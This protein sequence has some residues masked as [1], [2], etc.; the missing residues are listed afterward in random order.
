[1]AIKQ[2]SKTIVF[3]HGLFV[4]PKS[5][6]HWKSHFEA[7]GY[8]CYAPAN[9]A[10][11]GEPADLRKNFLPGL[12]QVT[13]KDVVVQV[14]DFIDTLPEKPIVIG[15]SLGGLTVQ[16]LVEMNRAAA[17]VCID[18]AAPPGI[19]TTKWSFW[20]S[21]FPVINYLKGNSVFEPDKKWFHYAFCNTMSREASDKVFDAYVVPESRNIP[22]G[23]LAGFAKI[24]LKKPHP[25][26]LFIAGEKDHIVPA[27]LNKKNFDAYNDKASSKEFKQFSGRGHYTCGEANWQQVADYVLDWISRL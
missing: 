1:M 27:S 4:N 24:D 21:N 15:H 8:T 16:K 11:E 5:W 18:G 13:F 22:R 12:G 9:P 14:A 6:E 26:L 10:H 20:R 7:Q 23:T 25:P 3:T 17:G 2:R 19:I